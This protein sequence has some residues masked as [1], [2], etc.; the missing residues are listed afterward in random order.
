MVPAFPLW[1]SFDPRDGLGARPAAGH[2]ARLRGTGDSAPSADLAMLS[3]HDA[4]RKVARFG[5]SHF[6]GILERTKTEKSTRVPL[7]RLVLASGNVEGPRRCT[8]AGRRG[9]SESW[10]R[11]C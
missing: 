8:P 1:A 2:P 4:R 11:I 10:N 5:V 3:F 6:R 9:F 7:E